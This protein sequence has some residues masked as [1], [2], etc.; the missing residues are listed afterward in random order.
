MPHSVTIRKEKPE[1][2]GAIRALVE[3]AFEGEPHSDGGEGKL[4]ERLRACSAYVPG[5]AL[6][7][8]SEGALVGFVLL[9]RVG[10]GEDGQSLALAPVAVAP[11]F[12]SRGVGSALIRQAHEEARSQGY[13]SVIVVGHPNYYPRFGYRPCQ[14]FGIVPPFEVEPEAFLAV[15]LCPGALDKLSG[16]VVYP[17]EFFVETA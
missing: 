15:A 11:A 3:R 2:Y 14:D 13:Q 9:T 7:A 10:V 8:E 5:L 12:Q 4:V 17:T 6:V 16:R 1:D